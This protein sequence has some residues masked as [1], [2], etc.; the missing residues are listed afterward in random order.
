[1]LRLFAFSS[2]LSL[3][4]FFKPHRNQ[5][6]W[7]DYYNLNGT[8]VRR[9]QS[10]E[11][12]SK[13]ML[14]ATFRR[15]KAS[16][17]KT[18]NDHGVLDYPTDTVLDLMHRAFELTERTGNEHGFFVGR[19]GTVTQLAEG[20]P[21]K[22]SDSV[23]RPGREYL[24]EMNDSPA[25]D[26][27]THEKHPPGRPEEYGSPCPDPKEGDS[28]P[29]NFRDRIQASVILAYLPVREHKFNTVTN[30]IQTDTFVQTIGFYFKGK[31]FETMEFSRFILIAHEINNTRKKT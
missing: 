26:V 31:C 24:S 6:S 8:L 25:Y 23:R 13:K 21:W 3:L 16:V 17:E 11:G 10:S 22:L 7:I 30:I 20:T 2:I 4:T 29:S 27:H 19:K 1:M 12:F 15:S 9:E 18:I 14:V 28:D 5:E